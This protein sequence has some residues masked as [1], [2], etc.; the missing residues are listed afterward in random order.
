[1][2]SPFIQGIPL[3]LTLGV[4]AKRNVRL[5]STTMSEN[6]PSSLTGPPVA[7]LV[8]PGLCQFTDQFHAVPL[9]KRYHVSETSRVLRFGLPDDSKPLDLST[10]ACLLAKANLD[11][12]DVIRPYTPI[13][14]NAD[15]GYFDLLVKD[16]GKDGRMSTFLTETLEEGS[17]MVEFGHI[18]KNVK[19]Q[20]PFSKYA[21]VCMLVGGTGITPMIQALHAILGD[22]T[23]TTQAV[24]LYGSKV[25]SDILGKDLLDNW[26]AE[27]TDRLSVVHVLSDEPADSDWEGERGFISRDLINKYLPPP[28]SKDSIIFVCGP[29]PMYN[30][31]CGPRDAKELTGLLADMGYTADQVYKF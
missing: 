26:S 19:I 22:A 29:P 12:E 18:D 13:S 5:L 3:I 28:S 9:L 23:S 30:A 8:K 7:S 1:M 15:V 2:I 11:G 10:C 25:A 16:Y 27:S 14:T 17:S 6:L 31:L 20:A 21:T 24:M 4:V